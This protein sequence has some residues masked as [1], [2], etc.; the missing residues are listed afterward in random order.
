MN[1]SDLRTVRRFNRTLT[2]RIGA[3]DQNFLG[4]GR[5]LGEARLIYEIGAAGED[6]RSL[7]TRLGLDAGYATRLMRSLERQKL[8]IRGT[9][10]GD[11]R[12]RTVRLSSKG[13]SELLR[14]S[15]DAADMQR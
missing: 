1:D 8:V 14:R 11:A 3:L 10:A 4:M 12:R 15:I 6:V 13:L 2:Q 9:H 5:P 7:R